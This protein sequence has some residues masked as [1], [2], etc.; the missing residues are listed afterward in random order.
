MGKKTDGFAVIQQDKIR[1]CLEKEKE[2]GWDNQITGEITAMLMEK[3][4]QNIMTTFQAKN[5]SLNISFSPNQAAALN[6][7]PGK[8]RILMFHSRDIEWR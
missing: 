4:T 6:L 1:I 8:Q 2:A 5:F 7:L 3:S